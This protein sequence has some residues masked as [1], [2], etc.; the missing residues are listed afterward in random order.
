MAGCKYKIGLFSLRDC[1]S[2]IAGHCVAC[3]RPV[4]EKHGRELE[5]GLTCLE[6]MAQEHEDE[7]DGE[8]SQVQ[9]R[10]RVHESTGFSGYYFGHHTH[11]YGDEE[12]EYF[13]M[14]GVGGFPEG[15]D[16]PFSEEGF[17]A[18]D[19]EDS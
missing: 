13:E 8:L 10:H 3:N 19:F 1:G 9:L 11:R 7:S 18:E 14:D 2:P 16:E 6:C 17:S 5:T 12:Y 15:D 4:C